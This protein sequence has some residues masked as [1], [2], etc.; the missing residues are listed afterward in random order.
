MR[1]MTAGMIS[2]PIRIARTTLRSG[3]YFLLHISWESA[4]CPLAQAKTIAGRLV[5]NSAN[6]LKVAKAEPDVTIRANSVEYPPPVVAIIPVLCHI[7]IPGVKA[8]L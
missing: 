2:V 8:Y 6:W 1:R 3:L 4:N 5:I 7:S